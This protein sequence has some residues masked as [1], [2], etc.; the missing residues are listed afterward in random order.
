MKAILEFDLDN[1]D[2]RHAHLR[3]VKS[4]D[5]AIVLNHIANNLLK[6]CRNKEYGETDT[7]YAGLESVFNEIYDLLE[8]NDININNL[9]N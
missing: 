2:D 6:E 9:I 3:C 1:F 8:E 4:L 7:Y 5:M